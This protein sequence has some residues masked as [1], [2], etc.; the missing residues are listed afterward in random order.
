MQLL[1]ETTKAK[2]AE[3]KFTVPQ[4]GNKVFKDECIYCYGDQVFKSD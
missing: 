2:L 4:G 3:Y 1:S